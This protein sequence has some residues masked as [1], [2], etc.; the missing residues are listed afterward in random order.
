MMH[1]E[2][3]AMMK[4]IK[5]PFAYDHFAEG[6]VPKPPFAVFLYPGSNN[7]SADGIVYHK[8][9]EL[10]I[11]LYTDEKNPDTEE[12]IEAVLDK[13]GLFYQKTENWIEEERLFEV[14]YE[15]EV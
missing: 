9:N 14:L 7:F 10:N 15:M 4:K 2:V 8:I 1:K 12:S 13:Y 6:E 11:E 3:M 5:L